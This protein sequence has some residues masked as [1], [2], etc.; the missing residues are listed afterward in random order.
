[1]TPTPRAAYALVAVALIA[2]VV[3]GVVALTL[4]AVVVIA[5]V[6]DVTF[7]H[8]RLKVRRTVPRTLS[9]GVAAHLLVE[10]DRGCAR[11]A[12][13]SARPDRPTS[14]STRPSDAVRST[15]VDR[16]PSR[17]RRCSRRSPRARRDRSGSG[18]AR[19]RARA[20][21]RCWCIPTWPPLRRVV[22]AL[23]RGRSAIRASGRTGPLGLG[24]DFESI[25][26]YLPDDDVRQINWTATERRRSADEQRLPHR[27]GSRR[28]VSPR[29]GSSDVGAARCAH[30]PSRRGRGRGDDGRA[31]RRRAGRPLRGHRV[32]CRAPCAAATAS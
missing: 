4:V 12:S 1:M 21:H 25:R 26:D 7:A 16:P 2:L 9:R 3:P 10:T 32:R 15:A 14:T 8:H 19:S 13:R 6:A 18:A 22:V 29:R 30:D 20:K 5:T 28:R 27:T 11:A 24:T 31:R 17:A 23:R